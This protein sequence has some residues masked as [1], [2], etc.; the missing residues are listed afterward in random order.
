MRPKEHHLL[1]KL[2][3]RRR[4]VLQDV[5]GLTADQLTF[6][7]APGSWSALDIIEHLVKVEEAIAPRVRLR[8]PRTLA[9]TARARAALAAMRVVFAVRG[10]IKVP[11]QG[12]LPLGGVTLRDLEGRWE[13]AGAAIRERLEEF[14]AGD[15]SRPMMRHPLLGLLTPAEGLAFLR[16]HIDHHRRQIRRAVRRSG[17]K[18]VRR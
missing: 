5:D 16:W 3:H 11:V 14:G 15:W 9:E 7:P 4:Q 2:E 1:T 18:A 8:P 12:I 13:A 6:R 10:R 17:G